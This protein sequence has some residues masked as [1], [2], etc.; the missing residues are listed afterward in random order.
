M[1]SLEPIVVVARWKTTA[2]SLGGVLALVAE[3]RERSLGEPG[4]LAYDVLQSV[5]EP[6]AL[7][8]LERYRDDAALEEHRR[9]S[10]YREILVER[11]LPLLTDRRVELLMR[12]VTARA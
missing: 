3:L 12:N 11:I 6:G 9:T 1:S 8:L 5:D 7:V 2:D 10:H 4:C